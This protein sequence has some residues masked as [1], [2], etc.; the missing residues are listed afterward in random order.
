MSIKHLLLCHALLNVADNPSR[1]IA[2]ACCTGKLEASAAASVE[3]TMLLIC[4]AAVHVGLEGLSM[5]LALPHSIAAR[6]TAPKVCPLT[7]SRPATCQ[8]SP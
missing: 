5:L 7:I 8:A 4:K 6:L 2:Y 3:R 1:M